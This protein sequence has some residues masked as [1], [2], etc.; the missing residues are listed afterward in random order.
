MNPT[1]LAS[2]PGSNWLCFGIIL[3]DTKFLILVME[4]SPKG[5]G[6]WRKASKRPR[7][8]YTIVTANKE[9]PGV[10]ATSVPR[11][12]NAQQP[13]RILVGLPSLTSL[14]GGVIS[15][16]AFPRPP[17]SLL[18]ILGIIT[19]YSWLPKH[20]S[21]GKNSP[22]HVPECSLISQKIN[23]QLPRCCNF[24]HMGAQGFLR[25]IPALNNIW[26]KPFALMTSLDRIH[27]TH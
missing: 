20:K 16:Y 11:F 23:P 22:Q 7:Q 18:I 4:L 2:H 13:R 25:S 10:W 15:T 12:H 6:D 19:L 1:S 8:R 5:N 21:L 27:L 14:T 9:L 24:W 3:I 26:P 17:P